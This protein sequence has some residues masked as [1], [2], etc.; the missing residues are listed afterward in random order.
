MDVP[1]AYQQ[2][3]LVAAD[4]LA[5]G[6]QCKD[7]FTPVSCHPAPPLPTL[8]LSVLCLHCFLTLDGA[9]EAED[10]QMIHQNQLLAIFLLCHQRKSQGKVASNLERVPQSP[11]L[12]AC[13]LCE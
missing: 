6:V 13:H 10:S 11:D 5:T 7:P 12:T 1:P 9:T 4:T 3:S 8:L 2:V